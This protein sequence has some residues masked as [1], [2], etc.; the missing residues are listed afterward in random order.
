M[1]EARQRLSRGCAALATV[2]LLAAAPFAQAAQTPAAVKSADQY[3]AAGNLKAAAIELRNAVREAP[4]DA[5]LRVRLARL[6]LQLGDA[7]SAEREA[8]A[9]REHN[10]AEADYLP[11][12]ADALLRQ[13][14][15]SQLADLVQPGNR[16]PA[17]ES[18][19]R[20]AL[21]MA[22]A[23]LGDPVKA[24]AM[25]QDAIRLDPKA[26]QPKIDLARLLARSKPAQAGQLLDEVLAANPK[27]VEALLVKGELARAQGKTQ[28]AMSQFDA[29]LQID[30]KNL[31][32]RLGRASLNIAEGKYKAADEDLD[33]I[34]KAAPDNFMANYL[35][36]L[37]EAKQQQ[38]A[39]ADRLFDRLS[40]MFA[41]YP[42]GYYLQGATKFAL[43]Q[44]AQAETVLGKYLA[45][46][47]N[48]ARA[49][50]IAAAAAL[51]QN[52]PTR[53][54]DVL[55]PIAAKPGADAPTLTLL[56]NAYM[57]ARK[58]ELALQQFEKAAALEPN[59]PTIQA[60]KAMSEIG[61]GQGKAGLAELEKVFDTESGA[62]IAGPTL[63]LLQMRAGQL[64]KATQVVAA[65]VKRDA[66]NPLYLT[67]SGMVKAAQKDVPG[68]EAAFQ[69]A[70]AKNPNFAPARRD[71][72]ALYMA[73]GRADD[74]KKLYEAA[75]AKKSDD[76]AALLGLAN[77]AIGEKKW[78]DAVGYV[79]RARTAAPNDPTPGLVLVRIYE[80]QKDWAN[81]KAVA[82]ALNAQFPSNLNILEAQ[83]QAQLAAGDTAG[84]LASYKRA[85]ELSPAS[86][87]LLSDYLR[88]LTSAK[89]YREARG[90]LADAISRD[91]KNSTL[92]AD[93]VRVTAQLDGVDAAVSQANQYA[94]EDPKSDAFPL[95]AAQVYGDAGRW[96]DAIALLEKAVA[97][98]PTDIPLTDTLA[99]LYIR[100]G[101]F[102]KAETMLTERLKADPKE[103][104][105]SG[106]L[107]QL[108]LATGRTVE[109]R[110]VYNDL[111]SQ[112]PNDVTGLL[113]LA[114]VSLA[115]QKWSEATGDIQR[116]AA[117]APK[118]PAPGIKLVNFYIVRQDWKNATAA[119]NDLAAKFPSNVDV[120]D[121]QARAE[122]GSGALD[123][124][125]AT[126]KRALELAPNSANLL[127]RYVAALEKAKKYVEA[128]SVLRA[129]LN[130]A[131][132]NAAIKADLIRVAAEIGGVDAGLAEA[133]DLAKNDPDNIIYDLASAQ[134][135]ERAKR[136][137]EAIGLLER[138]LAA[139]PKNDQLTTALAGLY[140]RAGND[141]KAETLLKARLQSDPANYAVASALA[142]LYLERKNYDAAMAEYGKIIQ[143]H[144]TDPAALNNLAWLYQQKGNLAK[145]RQ[146]AEQAVAASPSSAQ[147]DDTLGWIL[148]AQGDAAKAVT[149]LTAANTSA[150]SDPAI[151]YHLAAALHT[152]GRTADAQSLLEK[153]LGSGASFADKPK[154][155]KLLAELK[156]S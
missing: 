69:A 25:L 38:Y 155:E 129:T 54:I 114:D 132:Q 43:G 58:P 98:R 137:N 81:A 65:L 27:S 100:T 10:G 103:A 11:V 64:D 63:A 136:G 107:G 106:A 42:A 93:L 40:P 41:R 85:H 60:R 59:N 30:P 92:K 150:P 120:L 23:G 95:V 37:E 36:G 49:A 140:S 29:A 75:L 24:Q 99:R 96:N 118:D 144:P 101:S 149:Y 124:G 18:Q 90:V 94:K 12:L 145:A 86:M 14:K 6:Y 70:L 131:P 26:M 79:N 119:A 115:E 3:I 151:A 152:A 16:P 35:R 126:Y 125:I 116:A 9:A 28:A 62:P 76:V 7:V 71:L 139:K 104:A 5:Q 19:V 68:A 56:G 72:A 89:Y 87:P 110:K 147:I 53:A 143:D 46:V 61:S 121:A 127:V 32:A 51:R 122:I 33:P 20:R 148:L 134:L 73:N 45:L 80:L 135:L 13:G 34:L 8:R 133:R 91:P 21:G 109:A 130:R 153:L 108:Y 4:D 117:A 52:A 82:S 50:R 55:K 1:F 156:H 31:P 88:M 102:G 97:A 84:A 44:Y 154:A 77:I 57:A 128:Q 141:D 78:S 48:D 2:A 15:F 113:G 47:P 123:S 83:A 22:A 111:L 142:S 105:L 66:S 112:K 146:L 17:L 74:A 138:D 67:L 39:A